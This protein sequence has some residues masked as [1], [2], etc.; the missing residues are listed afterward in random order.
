MH[1]T[2]KLLVLICVAASVVAVSSSTHATGT[3]AR[4]VPH[5]REALLEFKG[6][7][8]SDGETASRT[9][10][11]GEASGAAGRTG[12]VRELHLRNVHAN[13]TLLIDDN[14][15]ALVGQIS[16]SLLSL[17]HLVHLD[18]SVQELQGPTGHVPEFLGSFKK[19]RY[20]NLSCIPFI[21]RVP[22]H[23]G[24][25]SRLQS[26][27]LSQSDHVFLS[28][29][30]QLSSTDISWLTRLPMLR[31][32]NMQYVNLSLAT[33]WARVVNTLPSLTALCLSQCS[34]QSANQSLPHHNLTNLEDLDLS[35]NY[36]V[37]PSASCWFWNITSLRRLNVGASHLYGQPPSA[38]GGL[39]HLQ[40]LIYSRSSMGTI[41]SMRNLCNLE[42]LDLR[43]NF[44]HGNIFEMLPRCSPNKLTEL[45]LEN[46]YVRGLPKLIGEF[47][48]IVTLDMSNNQ[49][50]GH[51]PSEIGMLN[52]LAYL[53][54]SNGSP[55]GIELLGLSTFHALGG[56]NKLAYLDL[57]NNQFASS[58]T[59]KNQLTGTIPYEI[60]MLNNLAYMDLSGNN[61]GGVV[62]EEHFANLTSLDFFF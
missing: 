38:L 37:Q 13:N 60:G 33:D 8:T 55:H 27:D 11:A 14:E 42:I 51:I 53:D 24:N 23:L 12:H 17:R 35:E 18:L 54:L 2:T 46:N 7:I 22:P 16:P 32:L 31:Y 28:L 40:V 62:T 1:P 9:A 30:A 26:L 39:Q 41:P 21:G 20:L 59:E 56:S 4:C 61:I 44:L 19:L 6:G 15:T 47:V 29:G 3:S 10:A 34:L 49:L 5:E 45:H 50:T 43:D 36:F 25:L 52:K 48:N 57:S 58:Q